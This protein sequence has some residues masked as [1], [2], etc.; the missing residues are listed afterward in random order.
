[1]SVKKTNETAGPKSEE[2]NLGRLF[3]ELIDHRKL[4]VI[5]TSV[6]TIVAIIY[7]IFSTPVYEANSMVQ[8]EE[9]QGNA[10]LQSLSQFLPNSGPESAPEVALLQSRLVLGKTVDDLNLQ[11]QINQN[12]FPI[13]GAGFARLMGEK[14]GVVGISRL[15]IHPLENGK[16]PKL[17]MTIIDNNHY[18]ID[19]YGKELLGTKNTL[20]ETNGLAI[21]VDKIESKPGT[22]FTITYLDRLDAIDNVEKSFTVAPMIAMGVDS[23]IL[24]LNYIDQNQERA[25]EILNRIDENYL[26]QNIE[27]QA[28]QDAK[29]L[30]FLNQQLPEVRNRLDLAEDKLNDY[31][32]KK[33]SIDLNL[34]A[35]T[36]L[37]QIVN[38]DNQLNE[39]TFKE[40]DVS[41]LF[42]KDHPTYK[43]LL[44]KRKTLNEEKERLTQHV[45]SMP[46]TQQEVIRLSRDVDS[47]RAIYMQLLNRQQELNI[48]KS[49]AIG[50]VRIIDSAVTETAPVKPKKMM[51]II[52]GLLIGAFTSIGIIIVRMLMKQG[53]ESPAQMEDLGIEVLGNIPASVWLTKENSRVNKLNRDMRFLSVENS[54][55]VAIE[56]IRNVRTSLYFKLQEAKNNIITISGATK[57]AGKTFLSSNLAAV[58]VQGNKKVLLIDADMR[59]GYLHDLFKL[60]NENGLSE[61]LSGKISID[62]SIKRYESAGLDVIT[63]GTISSYPSELLLTDNFR[64]LIEWSSANYDIVIIDTPPILAVTDASIICQLS[65]VNVLVARFEI[66]TVKEIEVAMKNL[67]KVGVEIDGCVLNGVLKKASNYYSY[68]YDSYSYSYDDKS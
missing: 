4:I 61:A 54:A 65:G 48:A 67:E 66:N 23:G 60:N 35:R 46:A 52:I 55:D 22:T 39:L 1:M 5:L 47:G 6:F 14:M 51:I 32:Q 43:A 24:K 40:A 26:A 59:R 13:F 64:R 31:R 63:R 36:T 27:R 9:K 56:A 30:D 21:F 34:E 33:D 29:S 58:F 2:I 11:T 17:K 28:A 3:G 15:Y 38:V 41:Q 42:T 18:R 10:L 49:S 8:V 68:G 37:D 62:K 7:S 50:N 25:Q 45:S 53:V 20:L 16:T 57:G 12:F 44:E 19:G